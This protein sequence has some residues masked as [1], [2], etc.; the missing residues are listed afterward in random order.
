MDRS[1]ADW[2]PGLSR[3]WAFPEKPSSYDSRKDRKDGLLRAQAWARPRPSCLELGI[4]AGN[5]MMERAQCSSGQPEGE[6][7]I[8]DLRERKGSGEV[9][10]KQRGGA[11]MLLGLDLASVS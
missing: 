5:V 1:P 4:H 10:G 3:T 9:G 11:A 6:G 8:N 7:R 2:Y